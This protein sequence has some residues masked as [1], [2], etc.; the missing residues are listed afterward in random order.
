[1]LALTPLF[2]VWFGLGIASKVA[3]VFLMAV[4]PLLINTIAGVSTVDTGLMRA[5]LSF[6]AGP[7][8]LY[9]DV[10]LPAS[11]PFIVAGIRLAVGRA[12]VGMVLGEFIASVGGV[13]YRILNAAALFQTAQYLAGVFLLVVASLILNA[14]IGVLERRVAPW[15]ATTHPN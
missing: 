7:L 2:V 3:V 5:A 10:I 8:A 12:I 4:T 9:R 11:T 15:R 13:G 1:M 6:G 14:L